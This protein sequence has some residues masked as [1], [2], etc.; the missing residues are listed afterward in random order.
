VVT[1][2]SHDQNAPSSFF[3]GLLFLLR[4]AKRGFPAPAYRSTR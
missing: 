1:R 3:A 2:I 4:P